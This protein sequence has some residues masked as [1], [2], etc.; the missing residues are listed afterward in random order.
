[1]TDELFRR[2]LARER[3]KARTVSSYLG[4]QANAIEVLGG[5]DS[6]R[7]RDGFRQVRESQ[8]VSLD[9]PVLLRLK[10]TGSEANVKECAPEGVART[11]EVRATT[12][13]SSAHRSAAEDDS[14]T[15]G[16][17]IDNTLMVTPK[18]LT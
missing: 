9:A 6:V 12:S 8:T 14:K 10:P 7:S 15:W 16:K 11:G 13:G 2:A 17:D 5:K 18:R 3:E 1:M 4:P